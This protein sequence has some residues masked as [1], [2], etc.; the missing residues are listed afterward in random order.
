[1]TTQSRTDDTGRNGIGTLD[2]VLLDTADRLRRLPESRLNKV[3]AAARGVAQSL[4][5]AAAGIEARDAAVSPPTR[6]VPALSVFAIADQVAVTAHDLRAAAAGV[7]PEVAVWWDG[8]RTP[9]QD[10]LQAL[11]ARVEQV[12]AQV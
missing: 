12:R 3:A 1:V 6:V 7:A 9:L 10:V 4:A 11:A 5:D 2:S 8:A